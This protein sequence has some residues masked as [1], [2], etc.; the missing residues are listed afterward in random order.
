MTTPKAFEVNDLLWHAPM[1]LSAVTA[2][3]FY[4]ILCAMLLEKS[5]I[6]VSDNLSLLSSAVLGMQCFLAPF[7][8]CH[9]AIPILPKSLVEM[10]EAPMPIIVGLLHTHLE[11][12]PNMNSLLYDD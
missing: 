4:K 8:W 2:D 12:M 9:V 7:R 5:I 1:F 3:D 6:F 10:I 11:Q